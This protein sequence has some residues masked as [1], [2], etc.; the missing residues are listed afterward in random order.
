M[1]KRLKQGAVEPASVEEAAVVAALEQFLR[2]TA[3]V[4]GPAAVQE[5]SLW[6]RAALA[7]GVAHFAE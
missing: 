2:V 3:R 5:P 6:K 7:E 4:S 1:T